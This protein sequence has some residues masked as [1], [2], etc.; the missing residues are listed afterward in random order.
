MAL[1]KIK[2]NSIAD[3]AVTSA[4]VA[5]GGIA[6]LDMSDGSIT[7]LKI[8]DGAIGTADL[9]DGS[10]TPAKL[11]ITGVSWNST[12]LSY[13]NISSSPA[14]GSTPVEVLRLENVEPAEPNDLVA[15]Q[16][17]AIT[18]YVPKGDQTSGNGAIIAGVRESATD[19]DSSTSLIFATAVSGSSPSEKVRIDSAGRVG[20]GI[21]P[22]YPI[23]LYKGA[24][25]A[26]SS[27][28]NPA[29]I[30]LFLESNTNNFIGFRQVGDDGSYCGLVFTD[31]NVGGY[32]AFRNA[33]SPN[34]PLSNDS[35]SLIYGSYWDH[36]FQ[37]GASNSING[38]NEI[39]RLNNNGNVGI[40][41]RITASH[42][43]SIEDTYNGTEFGIK[44]K[45]NSTA[46]NAE[47]KIRFENSGSADF[48]IGLCST[49]HS[50]SMGA[51]VAYLYQ[52]NNAPINMF[53]NGG[54]TL[55]VGGGGTGAWCI[56]GSNYAWWQT[57]Q[58]RSKNSSNTNIETVNGLK[59]GGSNSS[60][61]GFLQIQ[62]FCPPTMYRTTGDEP[63]P[64]GIGFGN[65]SESGGIMPI[66]AGDYLQEIMFYGANSGP[67]VFTFKRQQ[68]EA[69]TQD[70][71]ASNNYSGAAMTVNTGSGAV[72]IS[73][74]LSKGSGSFRIDHPLPELEE[75]HQLVHSFIEG[76]QADLIYRGVVTLVNG[77]AE[78]NIDTA[79]GM[80]EGTFVALCREVQ[81]FTSN[82]SDWDPVRGKVTGN[83]LTIECK[84]T[85]SSASISWMVVGERKDK[86]MFD[87]EW[88][89][90]NG[91]VIVEP[92]KADVYDQSKWFVQNNKS[93]PAT[94]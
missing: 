39:F 3:D 33:T 28:N 62:G 57:V 65:G 29:G 21:A 31:N 44:I 34:T 10:V 48:S 68:W 87:T 16:G 66:G 79:A 76:P 94:E 75:T 77:R 64:Y 69:Y 38:K 80:T 6:T 90:D 89:D 81:C 59:I 51:N 70:A 92:L 47:A 20:L 91:K 73:G 2:T 56:D 23:H 72:S 26:T 36:S 8:A 82:E 18:F 13:L 52:T 35:D 22:S 58:R 93:S 17:P 63:A 11:G 88:T 84:N 45:N 1:S 41:N 43:L 49:G 74:S 78:V 55:S 24:G 50:G 27:L 7:S 85:D 12:K 14:A 42:R 46:T 83:T 4:K 60:Q 25:S 5:T 71:A 9:A 30:N 37:T 53:V 67:T 32:I 86:H 19:T 54:Q 61:T 15:G 40:G